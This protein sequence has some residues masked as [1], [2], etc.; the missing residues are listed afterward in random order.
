MHLFIYLFG[1]RVREGGVLL[2]GIN[3]VGRMFD[4]RWTSKGA[5][6]NLKGVLMEAR[7]LE[8][9]FDNL[10]RTRGTVLSRTPG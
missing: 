4:V 6:S 8:E 3:S 7:G 10:N 5:Y 1:R 2:V 9:L